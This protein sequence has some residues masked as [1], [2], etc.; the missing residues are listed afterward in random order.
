[1]PNPF[2]FSSAILFSSVS[3]IAIPSGVLLT[4]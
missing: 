2:S 3:I 4:S 1:L